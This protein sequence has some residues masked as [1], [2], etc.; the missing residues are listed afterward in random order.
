MRE[1]RALGGSPAHF[2]EDVPQN[3]VARRC[4]PQCSHQCVREGEALGRSSLPI[5]RGFLSTVCGQRGGP[6]LNHRRMREGQALAG[7]PPIVA[8]DAPQ[9]AH[10]HRSELEYIRQRLRQDLILER[11]FFSAAGNPL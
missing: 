1:G 8:S 2:A 11:S 9:D 6:H 10:A 3:V 5:A 7:S 4:E